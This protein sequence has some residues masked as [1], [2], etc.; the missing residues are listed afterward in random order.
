MAQLPKTKNFWRLVAALLYWCEGGKQSLSSGI[1]FSN[2]DPELMKTFLSALRKGFTLDESKF[3]V[4]M[5]LHEYHDETKQQTFWSRV[6]NI[7]VAQFQKTYKKPHT[8]KRKH[9]NYEGCASLRYYNAGIVKNLIIIYS[10]FAKHSEG[11]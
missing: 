1:N 8:G 3:R 7:P 2:S 11:T 5:H 10:Q 6:T 4:L 9:L